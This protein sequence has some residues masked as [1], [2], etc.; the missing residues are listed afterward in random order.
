MG[1]VSGTLEENVLKSQSFRVTGLKLEAQG[2]G[3]ER[4]YSAD[5][6]A[7]ILCLDLTAEVLKAPLHIKACHQH[8]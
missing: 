7:K 1:R 4:L 6:K 8:I 3:E 5:P 2:T